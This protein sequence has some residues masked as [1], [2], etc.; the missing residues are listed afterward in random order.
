MLNND[1]NIYVGEK[2]EIKYY[3][4][5]DF[6]KGLKYIGKILP[7]DSFEYKLIII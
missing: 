4:K 6:F 2:T 7:N 3:D 1:G 5:N